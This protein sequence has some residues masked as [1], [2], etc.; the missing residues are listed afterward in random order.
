MLFLRAKQIVICPAPSLP[1]PH[2]RRDLMK[3]NK[4]TICCIVESAETTF[5]SIYLVSSTP[6]PYQFHV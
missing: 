5:Q 4:S 3:S 1:P 2:M 6:P